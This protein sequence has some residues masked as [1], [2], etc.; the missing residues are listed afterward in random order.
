LRLSGSDRGGRR[1]I[2]DRQ[3]RKGD[4]LTKCRHRPEIMVVNRLSPRNSYP[5]RPTTRLHSLQSDT[6]RSG[7][8]A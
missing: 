7:A 8:T 5:N 6:A 1:R 4:E 2:A 3:R